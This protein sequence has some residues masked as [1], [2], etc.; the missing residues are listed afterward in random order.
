MYHALQVKFDRRFSGN[1]MLT[2]AYTYGKGMAYQDGDDGRLYFYINQRRN[3]AR[4]NFD[5]THTFVQSYVY[6]L[7]FGPGKKWLTSG[8]V[9]NALGGWRVTGILTL[10]TGTPMNLAASGTALN[11]P[12]NNQLVD[13][14]APVQ[15]LHGIGPNSPWFSPSS[16][17]QPTAAGVFGNLGRNAL[18]GPGFFNLDASLFKVIRYKER[19]SLEL[20]AEALSFTN[21]PQYGN[22]NVDYTSLS[23]FGYITNANGGQPSANSGPGGNRTLQLGAKF[24]F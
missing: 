23:N 9:G 18:T 22:P 12:G 11:A 1:F 4:N 10:M 8:F 7:P 3:Y 13:E 15:I 5:R 24:N 20:R 21:T 2:T 16:F 17:A 19:Y 6:D 14:V